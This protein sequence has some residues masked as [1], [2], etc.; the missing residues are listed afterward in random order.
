MY[1]FCINKTNIFT[2]LEH[3]EETFIH[4]YIPIKNLKRNMEA[5]G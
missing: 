2:T 1:F 4:K 3:I 5:D